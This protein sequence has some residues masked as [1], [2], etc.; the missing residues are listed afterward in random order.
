MEQTGNSNNSAHTSMNS[1]LVVISNLSPYEPLTIIFVDPNSVLSAATPEFIPKNRSTLSTPASPIIN[2]NVGVQ[3]ATV[4]YSPYYPPTAVPVYGNGMIMSPMYMYPYQV[5]A[6]T[7]YNSPS[8]Y[9]DSNEDD[10][11]NTKACFHSVFDV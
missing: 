1:V 8:P 11:S 9:Y 2:T 4:V 7:A 6:M 5:Q 10:N 3:Y